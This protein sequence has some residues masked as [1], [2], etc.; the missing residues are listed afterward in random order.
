MNRLLLKS[1]IWELISFVVT[2]VLVFSWFGMSLNSFYFSIVLTT[3]KIIGL[4]YY[5]KRWKK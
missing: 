5:L 4:Y 2:V 1:L 3:L